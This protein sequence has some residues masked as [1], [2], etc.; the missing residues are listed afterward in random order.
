[1]PFG[2]NGLNNLDANQVIRKSVKETQSGAIAQQVSQVTG[3]LVSEEFNQIDL[4]YVAAGNGAGEIETVTFIYNGGQVALLT[5]SY[6]SSSRLIS[7]VRS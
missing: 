5:L 6:D 3:V 4:T 2:E 7:V 1:M